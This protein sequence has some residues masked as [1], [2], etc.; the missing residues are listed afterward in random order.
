MNSKINNSKG[1]DLIKG[2]TSADDLELLAKKIDVKIDGIYGINSIEQLPPKGSFII[3]MRKD[4]G[5]GHWVCVCDSYYFDPFGVGPAEKLKLTEYN[6]F[7]YQGVLNEYCGIWCLLFLYS[8]QHNRPDLLH[9]FTN[10]D[11]VVSSG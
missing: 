6:P 8:R 1:R 7:Q 3:L 10:L 2:I 11:V 4:Q 9:G 5:V